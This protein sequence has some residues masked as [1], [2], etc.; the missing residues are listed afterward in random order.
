MPDPAANG[1]SGYLWPY[2]FLHTIAGNITTAFAS[3]IPGLKTLSL[4][5]VALLGAV[6]PPPKRLRR[7]RTPQSCP[8]L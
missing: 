1:S 7:L 8:A 2:R 6:S 3:K 4:L 5:L